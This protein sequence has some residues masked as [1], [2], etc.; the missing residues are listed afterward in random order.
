MTARAKKKVE[1]FHA[2]MVV[3]RIEEWCV[4]ATNAEE[5]KALLAAGEGH[6]CDSGDAIHV[7]VHRLLDD[8]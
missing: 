6:R 5:A 2:T 1:T 3:T 8:H 4:D 7:E